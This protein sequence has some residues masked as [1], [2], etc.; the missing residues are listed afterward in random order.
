MVERESRQRLMDT[1]GRPKNLNGTDGRRV[2]QADLLA[3]RRRSEAAAAVD[4]FINVS[5]SVRSGHGNLDAR[6]DSRAV[7]AGPG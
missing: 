1:R 3:Q 2:A 4:R 5:R 6:A 7:G